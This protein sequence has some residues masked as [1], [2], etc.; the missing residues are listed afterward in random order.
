[1]ALAV[2]LMAVHVLLST[3]TAESLFRI[4]IMGLWSVAAV[5]MYINHKFLRPLKL[6]KQGFSIR[7][8][9]P[10]GA[11]ITEIQMAGRGKL[12]KYKAGQ[13]AF[14]RISRMPLHMKNTLFHFHHLHQMK[15]F[16]LQ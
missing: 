8:V 14:F 1:M 5:L 9:V 4:F 6:K 10:L 15:L 2:V 16:Q 7:K 3:S 13:F 12:F 11:G